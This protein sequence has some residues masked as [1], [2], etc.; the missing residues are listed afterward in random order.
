[1][2]PSQVDASQVDLT[3]AS[4]DGVE[5]DTDSSGLTTLADRDLPT[6]TGRSSTLLLTTPADV[7]ELPQRTAAVLTESGFFTRCTG[8]ADADRLGAVLRAGDVVTIEG[9]GA[10]HS[11]TWL[12]WTVRHRFSLDAFKMQFTLV[13]NG[14]GSAPAASGGLAS[15][16]AGAF[17]GAV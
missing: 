7:T 17:G 12:V 3:Q 14:V 5:T 10:I 16:A 13:R 1:M 6:Y 2:R 4:D 11:G 9:A 15:A 8:E